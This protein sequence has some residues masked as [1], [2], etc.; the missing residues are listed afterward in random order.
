M[1]ETALHETGLGR[2]HIDVDIDAEYVAGCCGLPLDE[3]P[4]SVIDD[5]LTSWFAVRIADACE[6]IGRQYEMMVEG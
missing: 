1:F 4:A 5:I 3:T 2:W 6:D